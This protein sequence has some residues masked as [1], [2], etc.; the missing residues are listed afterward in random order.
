MGGSLKMSED[1]EGAAV[2]AR[3]KPGTETNPIFVPRL[4]RSILPKLIPFGA[5]SSG[6][7]PLYHLFDS[8]LARLP[9]HARVRLPRARSK[10]IER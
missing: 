8:P 9:S 1:L 2:A 7:D 10:M 3:L 5:A 6:G 4:R